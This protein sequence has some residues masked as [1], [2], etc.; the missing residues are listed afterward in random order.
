MSLRWKIAIAVGAMAALATL[1]VGLLSYRVARDR[2]YAEIDVSL[3]E[4]VA[5]SAV[6]TRSPTGS[7]AGPARRS[8]RFSYSDR[9]G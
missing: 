1:A 7:R 8:I 9:D 2:M 6:P 3:T 4:A 5:A